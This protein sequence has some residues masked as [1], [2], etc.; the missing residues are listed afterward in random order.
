MSRFMGFDFH[1]DAE[2]TSKI[3]EEA[4]MFDSK[5][6]HKSLKERAMEETS[7]QITKEYSMSMDNL[8]DAFF[9]LAKD[10]KTGIGQAVHQSPSGMLAL[11]A[12]IMQVWDKAVEMKGE[13]E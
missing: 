8:L 6:D 10:E 13:K 11:P 5:P 12:L 3:T 2:E 4:G 9:Q 1:E 7:R